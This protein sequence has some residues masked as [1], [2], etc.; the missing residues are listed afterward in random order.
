MSFFYCVSFAADVILV[1]AHV[2]SE[3]AELDDS[4]SIE[5]CIELEGDDDENDIEIDYMD[6]QEEEELVRN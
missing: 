5:D 4:P 2:Q 3:V 6:D 1:P